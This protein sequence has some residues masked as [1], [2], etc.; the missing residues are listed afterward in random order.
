MSYKNKKNNPIKYCR[1]CDNELILGTNFTE[2]KQK[3]SN[4]ICNS[5]YNIA[6]KQWKTTNLEKTR[7]SNRK[8]TKKWRDNNPDK[9]NCWRK[10]NPE[11]A[12]EQ[13]RRSSAKRRQTLGYIQLDKNPFADSVEVEWHHI[14]DNNVLA[15][16]KDLHRSFYTGHNFQLHRN[17][18]EYIINQIYPNLV[19]GDL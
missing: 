14:D 6:S 17:L 4:Y 10:A 1:D 9:I 15:I 12:R 2:I 5:C 16:P 3:N 7:C 18:L 11:R 8:S 13:W 19:V